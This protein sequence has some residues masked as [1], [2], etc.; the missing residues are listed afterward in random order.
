MNT[1]YNSNRGQLD[2]VILAIWGL[3]Q[4]PFWHKQAACCSNF[5]LHKL[6]I[7]LLLLGSAQHNNTLAGVK[8]FKFEFAQTG[9]WCQNRSRKMENK[10]ADIHIT[11]TGVPPIVFRGY[12]R[13]FRFRELT[14]QGGRLVISKEI[15]S[16]QPP[17]VFGLA[18]ARAAW[19]PRASYAAP[20]A[21]LLYCTRRVGCA[22]N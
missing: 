7:T 13:R 22:K 14:R 12:A 18:S 19:Y 21:D 15:P 4:M 3:D 10:D 6:S 8:Q 16:H 5:C 9:R 17:R 1:P 2:R 20:L 11:T